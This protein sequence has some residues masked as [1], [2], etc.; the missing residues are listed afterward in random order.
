MED[1]IP[2]TLASLSTR[3][4]LPSGL[5]SWI[6]VEHVEY[7]IRLVVKKYG[8]KAK[9]QLLIFL[10]VYFY[11][12][13]SIYSANAIILYFERALCLDCLRHLLIKAILMDKLLFVQIQSIGIL[14]KFS[15]QSKKYNEIVLISNFKRLILFHFFCFVERYL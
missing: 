12:L 14:S 3:Y 15:I 4:R 6:S 11:N 10:D 8:I 1:H 2:K 9:A 13:S 7:N 5:Y